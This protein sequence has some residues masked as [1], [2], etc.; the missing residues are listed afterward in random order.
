MQTYFWVWIFYYVFSASLYSM[1]SKLL[2]VQYVYKFLDIWANSICFEERPNIRTLTQRF[3]LPMKIFKMSCFLLLT[4]ILRQFV[5]SWC[6]F[7]SVGLLCTLIFL[8]FFCTLLLLVRVNDFYDD[9][10]VLR[11]Q[12]NSIRYGDFSWTVCSCFVVTESKK[13]NL[14]SSKKKF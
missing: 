14:K 2:C 1:Y 13:K 3:L 10:F 8:L 7:L 12:W 4:K 9:N 6:I 5:D 11:A